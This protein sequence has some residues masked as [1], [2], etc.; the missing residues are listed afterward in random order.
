MYP[1][2]YHQSTDIQKMIALIRAYPLGMLVSA[3]ESQPFITHIPIIY[4]QA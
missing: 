4:N 3:L 2:P 1:P